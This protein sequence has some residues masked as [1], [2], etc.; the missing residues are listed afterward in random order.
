MKTPT[1]QRVAAMRQRRQAIGLRRLELY[2]HPDD[3][4]RLK[5]LAEAL[6]RRRLRPSQ[7]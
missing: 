6:Q 7:L 2:A 4:E 1:A 5:R 3:H